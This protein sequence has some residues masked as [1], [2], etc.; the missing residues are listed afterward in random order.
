MGDGMWY[1]YPVL[2]LLGVIDE[3][4]TG[5]PSVEGPIG[6]DHN[7]LEVHAELW[8]GGDYGVGSPLDPIIRVGGWVYDRI[9]YLIL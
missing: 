7:P 1:A 2:S 3:M 5:I 8:S 9:K 6:H 4:I